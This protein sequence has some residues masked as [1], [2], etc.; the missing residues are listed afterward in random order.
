[1]W[2]DAHAEAARARAA[3]EDVSRRSVADA[4]RARKA[5][6]KRGDS[7]AIER[8]DQQE[9][10]RN[11][12]DQR[13]LRRV[14]AHEGCRDMLHRLL[15]HPEMQKVW[16]TLERKGFYQGSI[17][18]SYMFA[19]AARRAWMGPQREETWPRA[20][21]EQWALEV[22]TLST[23]LAGLLE[24]TDAD[25]NILMRNGVHCVG[26]MSGLL[27]SLGGGAGDHLAP[28]L[29]SRPGDVLAKRAY[30]V[31][32]L[33]EWFRASL[34]GPR[35]DAIRRTW[36]ALSGEEISER[37]VLELIEGSTHPDTKTHRKA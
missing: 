26:G 23:K 37:K 36:K 17:T 16:E 34:H 8:I 21:R 4:G 3:H 20:Q 2:R 1:M 35:V 18:H 15:L 22:E 7:T 24:Q 25:D 5:A 6:K 33:A 28:A 19:A 11:R 13:Q 29:L 10:E 9:Q 31:R 30:F 27:R 32:S 12:S 14:E